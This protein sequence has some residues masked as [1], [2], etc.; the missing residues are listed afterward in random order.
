H[1]KN[2]IPQGRW[3]RMKEIQFPVKYYENNI[4]YTHENESWAFY[5]LKGFEY[6]YISDNKKAGVAGRLESFFAQIGVETHLLTLPKFHQTREI[7]EQFKKTITGPLKAAAIRHTEEVAPVVERA[8]GAESTDYYFYIGVKLPQ[9]DDLELTIKN[10]VDTFR[11]IFNDIFSRMGLEERDIPNTQIERVERLE[12]MYHKIINTNIEARRVN[13]DDFQW[14]IKRNFYRGIGLPPLVK[15]FKPKYQPNKKGRKPLELIHL[16]EGIV[17]AM[18]EPRKIILSQAIDGEEKKGH[19]AFLTVSYI[20]TDGLYNIGTEWIYAIQSLD[21]PV[22]ISIRTSSVDHRKVMSMVKNKKKELKDQDEHAASTNNDTSYQVIE[23]VEL[24]SELERFTNITKMPQIHVS[25]NICVSAATDSDLKSRIRSVKDLYAD[26]K[27]QLEQ[28]ISDQFKLFNEFIPGSKQYVTAY[29]QMMEPAALAAGM[30]GAT[31]RIGDSNGFCI[32]T[33]GDRAVYMNPRLYTQGLAGARSRSLSAVFV[34]SKGSGKSYGGNDIAYLSVLSGAKALF[35]DPKGDRTY[36][37]E[38]LQEISHEVNVITLEPTESNKGR[39]DPFEICKDPKEA[40]NLALKIL[41]YL[42]KIDQQKERAE[43][44]AIR[45]AVRE[46]ATNPKPCM[47]KVIERLLAHEESEAGYQMGSFLATYQDLSF[48]NLLFGNGE[49]ADAL[50]IEYAMNVL[51]IQNLKMPKANKKASDFDM[52]EMLSMAMMFPI[53]EFAHDFIKYDSS[54]M[55]IVFIDESWFMEKT[56]IGK[57]IIDRLQREGRSR[58][59][60]VYRATQAIKD[61]DDETKALIGLKFIFQN[62]DAEEAANALK[63]LGIEPTDYLVERVQNLR[64]GECFMQDIYGRTGIVQ[65]NAWFE[66]LDR[67]FDTRPPIEKENE[68]EEPIFQETKEL[69]H[70]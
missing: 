9:S 49:P 28:P 2:H 23:N 46:V 25:I 1:F 60:G 22:E 38:T 10:L 52:E 32:G 8:V 36:W 54:V 26:F 53:G 66:D 17:D 4:I 13:E 51:Q 35:I 37:K 45:N 27:F 19:C 69:V 55:K 70:A 14:M 44:I 12:K 16:T 42:S 61:V 18:S 6:D 56:D 59:A 33:Q 67:A 5:E 41:V 57:D 58:N 48:A 50:N 15:G 40:E 3:R 24:V 68:N 11:D 21:F 20:P 39:L 7:H 43:W 62:S 63:F 64:V 34:G 30:F 47:D 65:L 29:Q 31:N